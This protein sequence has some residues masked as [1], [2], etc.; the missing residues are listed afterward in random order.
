MLHIAKKDLEIS[1]AL[2]KPSLSAFYSYSS[3]IG[4]SDRLVASDEIWHLDT[5][6]YVVEGTNEKEW[7]APYNKMTKSASPQSFSDQFDLNAGQNFGLSLS[8]P[9]L[10][11]FSRRII[12][13]IRLK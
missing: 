2:L 12:T 5:I 8:I 13:L 11:N 1:K 9:I 7:L 6:G 4:Y 10:N 3:R